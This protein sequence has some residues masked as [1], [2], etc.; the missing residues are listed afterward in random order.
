M[1]SMQYETYRST[2]IAYP[3]TLLGTMFQDRNNNLL[4]PTNDNEYFFDR[5][6]HTFRYIMQYY[7]TGE[8]AWPRR[9][10]FSDPWFQDISGTELKRELDYF[11]IPTAGIGLLLDE[12]E[13][14]FERAAATR[15]DD[16]MN[17]L[18]EALFETITNFKTK[19]GITFNWDRS[20]PTVNP[21]IERVIKI[22]GP[23][24]TIGYHILYMFGMEIEKY[25]QTLF[26]QLEVRIDK[27]FTDTPRAYVNVYMYSNNALDRN[28][29]LSYSCLA[30]RE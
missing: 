20:E 29:I 14:S 7:R 30:E 15:V 5:D 8:I 12:D 10:K 28:K 4:R 22:V 17:A 9:T 6:G 24:G 26:P 19:V 25:L 21:R 11:Q 23:F 13:P 1:T 27:F 16:F 2:L 18:K 3:D